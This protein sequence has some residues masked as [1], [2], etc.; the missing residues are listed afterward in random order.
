MPPTGNVT[1][2][3]WRPCWEGWVDHPA[4]HARWGG[5]QVG[6]LGRLADPD[7]SDLHS[8]VG[9]FPPPPPLPLANLCVWLPATALYCPIGDGPGPVW[10]GARGR[11]QRRPPPGSRRGS[12]RCRGGS[13]ARRGWRGRGAGRALAAPL[14]GSPVGDHGWCNPW[15]GR[16]CHPRAPTVSLTC[17]SWSPFRRN[18]RPSWREPPL[19][20][21]ANEWLRGRAP[22][23]AGTALALAARIS[24]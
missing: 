16:G 23:S 21:C 10:A 9:A 5:R 3:P 18:F 2:A 7:G 8:Q 11:Q 15:F 12:A 24:S 4:R 17:L 13:G 22:H 19:L 6:Q 14:R 20:P 1:S